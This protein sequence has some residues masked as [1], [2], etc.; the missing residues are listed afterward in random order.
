M[1][2]IYAIELDDGTMVITGG[3][4]KLTLKMEGVYMENALRKLSRVRDYL[5]SH[6]IT[7]RE[8]LI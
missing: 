3:V 8:G 1:L 7:S 2:R 6:Q 4:I 5:R